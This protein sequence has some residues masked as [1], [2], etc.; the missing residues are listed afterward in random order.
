VRLLAAA[1]LLLALFLASAQQP[2]SQPQAPALPPQLALGQ[3]VYLEKCALCHGQKGEGGSAHPLVGPGRLR[4][5]GDA[6]N[7]FNYTKLTMPFDKPQSLKD[8]E[9]WAVVAYILHLNNLLP[10]D[11]VLS[12]KNAKDVK[13]TPSR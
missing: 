11:L 1:S 5:Y 4:G 6:L 8:E 9:Y 10:K 7:L 2:T 3:K 13:L 12:A